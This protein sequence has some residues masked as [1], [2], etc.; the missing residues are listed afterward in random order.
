MAAARAGAKT[1]LVERNGFLGGTATA[2]MVC[3]IFNCFYTPGGQPATTGI[4]LEIADALAEATGYGEKWRRHKGHIIFDLELGKLVLA[5]LVEEAGAGLLVD[6]TVSDAVMDGDTL[7]GVIVES[8]SGREAILARVVV[9][10]TGDADVAA[11]SGVPLHAR[12]TGNHSYC[13]RLGGVD[14]DR[15]V[16][17]LRDNPG[18]YPEHMDVDWDMDEVI[19][20]YEDCGTLLFPHGGGIQMNALRRAAEAGDLPERIGMHDE[21]NACQMHGLRDRGTM[22]IITGF[23]HFDG[24]DV[25]KI[26]R[27]IHDGK[28]MAFAVADVYRKYVPGF[29]DS[30]VTGT[31]DDLGVR[32]SRYLDG[33]F[34]FTNE[35]LAAGTRAEDAIGRA[36]GGDQQFKHAGEGAWGVSVPRDGSFDIPYRCLLPKRVEGLVMGAGRSVSAEDPWALR[37]MVHTMVVGQGAGAAAAVAAKAECTPRSV[38]LLAVQAELTRQ[39]VD[40]G[41]A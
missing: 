13:F 23:V 37:V 1:L 2:G 14:L 6:T 12:E 26:A 33:D 40:L 30:F 16:Q 15:F 39:G 3:S 34:V 41:R 4:P 21:L 19:S 18:E 24:L 17:Y 22:H 9:D 29:E 8:K 20:Q 36:L 28:R 7:K 35:M 10:A 5:T 31:A 38:D 11:R 32:A 25:E 27:S